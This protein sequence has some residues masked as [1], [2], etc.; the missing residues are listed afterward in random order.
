[1]TG[2]V[3]GALP[4]FTFDPGAPAPYSAG[5]LAFTLTVGGI[6]FAKGD[7]FRFSIEGGHFRWRKNAGSWSSSIAIPAAPM[8]LDSGLSI[9]FTPGAAP[10][11]VANDTYSFRALQ[12]WAV[13][14]IQSPNPNRWQWNETSP[15]LDCDL[16][17]VLPL[18]MLA[19]AFHTLPS[20]CTI[21]VAGGVAGISDWTET[22]TW[23]KGAIAKPISHSA[24]YLRLT[25]TGAG[26]GKGGGWFYA[27][28]SLSTTYSADTTSLRRSY[29]LK[30]GDG[31]LYQ[32]GRHLASA[33]SGQIEWKDGFL[34]ETD[35]ANIVAL[36]DWLKENDDEP[37]LFLPNVTRPQEAYAVRVN[38]DDVDLPDL[39]DYNANAGFNRKF[40]AS[41]PLAGVWQ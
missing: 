5:G 36:L 17:S 27:G 3:A 19:L 7:K 9:T 33:V 4:V 8:V 30:R 41:L 18:D 2:S 21:T 22:L 40:S 13:S 26:T 28:T 34:T 23:Q 31:G 12:P 15:T 38:L 14:N 35:F 11:F 29:N 6:P 32:G 25:I 16:G 20:T 1:V 24:R 37:F 39:T 10:S